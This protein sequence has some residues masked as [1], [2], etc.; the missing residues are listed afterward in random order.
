MKKI[1]EKAFA[2]RQP[3]QVLVDAE[4]CRE[5]LKCK[6]V[7]KEILP[8]VLGG[9]VKIL[10]STCVLDELRKLDEAAEDGLSGSVFIAKRFEMRNCRH[11]PG[12]SAVECVEDL[13]GTANQFHYVVAVQNYE[14][15]KRLREVLGVPL[16]FV[17]R[18][19]VLM[20]DP[21]KV[22][23]EMAH[24]KELQKLRPKEFELKALAKKEAEDKVNETGEEE[25]KKKKK[26]GP[27]QP[28]PLSVRKAKKPSST[29]AAQPEAP[30][31]PKRKRK[32]KKPTSS[33]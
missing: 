33:E 7:A 25:P 23:I 9:P 29:T 28:N 3:Y 12:K 10:A 26:K 4:F 13:I 17:N 20:E 1:F 8:V 18:G 31:K 22:T 14:L 2:F 11:S 6:V 5:L 27:K 15:R 16:L 32:P 21:S 19:V 24:Q 30:Y